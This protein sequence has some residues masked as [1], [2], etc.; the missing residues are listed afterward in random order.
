MEAQD[1]E[2]HG[3]LH[4]EPGKPGDERALQNPP[5]PTESA[6][7]KHSSHMEEKWRQE[8]CHQF[9]IAD[10]YTNVAAVIIRWADE[11]DNLHC[12]KEAWDPSLL[13]RNGK[14]TDCLKVEELNKLFRDDFEY[15]S[16]I[17]TLNVKTKPQGQ[18]NYAISHLIRHHDGPHQ[19]HLLIVYYSGHGIGDGENELTVAG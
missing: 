2:V 7:E 10:R 18:L 17:V 15:K 4:I 9:Q 14:A 19:S 1:I 6:I 8:M 12:D 5:S 13:R 11:L 3:L 16:S